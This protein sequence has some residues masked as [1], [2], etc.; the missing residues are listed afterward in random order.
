M[1]Y[2]TLKMQSQVLISKI[3][4]FLFLNTRDI[5]LLILKN[6]FHFARTD[7]PVRG[8]ALSPELTA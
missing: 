4:V 3:R 1:Q 7:T 5:L 6:T 8:T 2:I